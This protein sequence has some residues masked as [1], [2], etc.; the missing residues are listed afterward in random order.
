MSGDFVGWIGARLVLGYWVAL[1]L[2]GRGLCALHLFIPAAVMSR[3]TGLE[4]VLQRVAEH[5]SHVQR[6]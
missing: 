4:A 2:V 6:K 3:A 5:R 1:I